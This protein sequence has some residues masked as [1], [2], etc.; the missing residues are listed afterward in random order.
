MAAWDL[1]P[2]VIVWLRPTADMRAFDV[3]EARSLLSRDER[4]RCDQFRFERDQRD[5]AAAHALL[6][7]ALTLHGGLPTD[8]WGFETGAAGKPLLVGHPELDFSIAHTTGLVACAL[9]MT[10]VVG[11]D[12]E[13]VGHTR[14][15]DEIAERYFAESEIRTFRACADGFE[16]RTRFTELWTL[17]E[18]YLK[19]LGSG[20]GDSLNAFG[21]EFRDQS[22]LRFHAPSTSGT[23]EWR[24]GL[25]AP[26]PD[27]RLA[28]A[29]RT[30]NSTEV[31]VRTWPPEERRPPL[32]ALRSWPQR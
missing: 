19:A 4:A 23:T 9:S 25:F 28:L 11:V 10:G 31:C 29:V 27:H 3:A 30:N 8:Y 20:L 12:V 24:F 22:E 1:D 5:F 2:P 18:A 21:F 7:R 13:L 16:R 15:A 26:S 17:K 6:R 32:V 14:D